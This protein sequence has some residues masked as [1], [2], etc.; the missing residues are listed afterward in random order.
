MTV[1]ETVTL[2]QPLKTHS[3]EVT[4]LKLKAPLAGQFLNHGEPFKTR[5]VVNEKG[6]KD[7]EFDYN[8]KALFAFLSDMTE[9]RV[10]DL[11]LK[12]LPVGDFY[13]LRAKATR[14]IIGLA[15]T[16]P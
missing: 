4:E 13:E 7:F 14:L 6:E 11:I 9:P 16:N 15:G 10:D 12:G 3:G 2:S 8:Y 5:V 1:L